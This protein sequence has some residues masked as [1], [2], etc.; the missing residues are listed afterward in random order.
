MPGKAKLRRGN[1]SPE[2]EQEW[3]EVQLQDCD[4]CKYC[5]AC[6]VE[7]EEPY[8]AY[9]CKV[10]RSLSHE[11]L[12][13]SYMF[14]E[15]CGDAYHKVGAASVRDR[16]SVQWWSMCSWAMC[17]V[18]CALNIYIYIHHATHPHSDRAA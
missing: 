2:S 13:L 10:C 4:D 12:T 17:V 14:C 5:P 7:V 16:Q 6:N 9:A 18:E 15:K 8:L 3:T 1:A 11:K